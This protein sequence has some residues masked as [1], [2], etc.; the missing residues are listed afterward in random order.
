MA[1]YGFAGV[2]VGFTP[3]ISEVDTLIKIKER[4]SPIMTP[5]ASLS[6]INIIN[7]AGL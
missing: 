3:L 7:I 2:Q 6:L 4:E 1:V 5:L